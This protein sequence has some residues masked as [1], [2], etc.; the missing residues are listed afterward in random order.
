MTRDATE[1]TPKNGNDGQPG[2]DPSHHLDPRDVE[3]AR[4]KRERN[5]WRAR[6]RMARAE[7]DQLHKRLTLLAQASKRFATSMRGGTNERQRYRRRIAAQYAVSQVLAHARDLEEAAP[8]IM[9]VLG[10]RLGWE[11]GVLWTLSGDTLRCENVW[12][13]WKYSPPG[14]FEEACEQTSFSRGVGLPGRVWSRGEPVW[15][16]DLLAEE[17]PLCEAAA[18]AGLRGAIAF[19]VRDGGLLGVFEFFRTE[20]LTLDEDLLRTVVLVGR[21]VGQFV[22]R[23]RAETERDRYLLRAQRARQKLSEILESI[24]EQFFAVDR[25]WRYTYINERSL[26]SLQRTKGEELTREELLGKTCWEVFPELVGTVFYHKVHES[27]REQRTIHFEEYSPARKTWY[28]VHL[29]PSEEG[30]SI[31]SQDITE[32]KQAEAE[33]LALKDELDT[34]LSAMTRLHELSTQLFAPSELPSLLEEVLDASINLQGADFGNIQLYNRETGNL[35]IVAQRGF[36]Q[37]FL[38]YFRHTDEGAACG[39]AMK[40]GKRVIVEDVEKDAEYEP[41]RQIAASAGYRAVQSTPLFERNGE[42]LGM[43]STH[44]R[45][46]HRPAE[47]ELRMTDIYARQAA[48]MIGAKLGEERLR[49][50]EERLRRAMDIETVGTIFFKTDGSITDANDTFLRM[51]GYSREELEQGKVR[52]DVMTPPEWMTLSLKAMEEFEATGR[53][54]PYEKEYFSKDGSRWWALFAATRLGEEEGVEFIIDITERKQAEV[55]R[56]RL[57]ARELTARAQSE[58]RRRLSRE[59]H[60]RVAHDMALVHQSLELYEALKTSDPERASTKLEL[61]K[62]KARVA[63]D[64]TRDLSMELR[65]PEV[66]RGLEAAFADLLRDI[67]PPTM[68]FDLSVGGDEALV[69]PEARTQLFLILREAI[70]NAVTYSECRRISVKLAITPDKIVGSVEDDGQGFQAVN[71]T[72]GQGLRLMEERAALLEGTIEISSAPGEGTKVRIS[73]PNRGGGGG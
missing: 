50:S 14:S 21:Q 64:S 1:A 45:K 16:E 42:P 72:A 6:E 71:E 22:E 51:S 34:E 39:R 8:E 32:R 31:Y 49:R 9:Q 67:V 5:E 69:T 60:D 18:E 3:I 23:R 12:R 15:A 52:W 70:R 66:R 57:I 25:D 59:L 46:P 27:L 61:A 41:H 56:D 58:E 68:S 36:N 33:L 40:Q 44:F 43:L 17:D 62:A 53:T 24:T 20:K 2:M 47:R 63:L 55:E 30:L 10:E 73:A 26:K 28:E 37:E 48:E 13:P 11:T 35:D 29:Y 7:A 19:P 38:D 54:T 4:L 65:Q